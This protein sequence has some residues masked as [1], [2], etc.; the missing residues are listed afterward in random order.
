MGYYLELRAPP[1]ENITLGELNRRVRLAGLTPHAEYGER[2][3]LFEYGILS[4]NR[5]EKINAGSWAWVRVSW[6]AGEEELQQLIELAEWIG[7]RIF[8]A[9]TGD[10]VTR[11]N[12]NEAVSK[13]RQGYYWAAETIGI[14]T[15]A[16]E[17]D[18]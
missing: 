3:F 8:D 2:D 7:A 10:Y 11:Q 15:S 14:G 1:G 13:L 5:P 18:D 4:L 6:S 12:L 17:D 16:N 9:S